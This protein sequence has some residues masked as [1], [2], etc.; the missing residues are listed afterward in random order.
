MPYEN[1][2]N[3]CYMSIVSSLC[4]FT[5]AALANSDARVFAVIVCLYLS[6]DEIIR[7]CCEVVH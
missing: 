2:A 1:Q 4:V 6:V 3:G 7:M 5:R